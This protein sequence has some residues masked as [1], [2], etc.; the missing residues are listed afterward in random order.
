MLRLDPNSLSVIWSTPG[1]IDADNLDFGATPVVVDDE[2]VDGGKGRQPLRVRYIERATAVEAV[3]VSQRHDVRRACNRWYATSRCR[4]AVS[5]DTQHG[6]IA[7]LDLHG[8]LVW[9]L[10][11]GDDPAYPNK[12]VLSPPAI[13]QGMLFIGYTQPNCTSNCDGLGAF[14]LATGKRLWWYS[15]PIADFW[16][17]RCRTGWCLRKR[18]RESD[19]VLFPSRV[20]CRVPT[21]TAREPSMT[22]GTHAGGNAYFHDPW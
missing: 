4:T 3:A 20:E 13:S 22:Y 8:N 19:D 6:G 5:T 2:V 1:P 11:T 21:S 15:T 7:V 16:R 9:S 10:V 12:A 14:D 18:D 17:Y